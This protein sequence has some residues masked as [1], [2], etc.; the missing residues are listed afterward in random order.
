MTRQ[1]FSHRGNNR[2]WRNRAINILVAKVRPR[3]S[4]SD[5]EEPLVA[6]ESRLELAFGN[7]RRDIMHRRRIRVGAQHPPGD[8]TIERAGIDVRNPEPLGNPSRNAALS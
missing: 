6:F 2:D 4:P 8:R 5:P 7:D 1:A 3:I